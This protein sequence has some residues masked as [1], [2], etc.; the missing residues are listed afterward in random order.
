MH[1]PLYFLAEFF[2]KPPGF[3]M[4]LAAA[5][6]CAAIASAPLGTYIVSIS[7]LALTGV[8]LIQNARDTA[9]MQAK[10]NEIIFALEAARNEVVGLE[11]ESPEDINEERENIETRAAAVTGV[12]ACIPVND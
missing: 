6:I 9:A 11:H 8:V 1:R 7:A 4:L 2:S 5:L 10:L 3:Y 12:R